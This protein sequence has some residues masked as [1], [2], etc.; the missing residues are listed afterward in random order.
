MKKRAEGR[1]NCGV[2]VLAS[3]FC[4]LYPFFVVFFVFGLASVCVCVCVLV[5]VFVIVFV[6]VFVFVRVCVCVCVLVC[7]FVLV[8]ASSSFCSFR[9]RT[10]N[11]Y[12]VVNE[13]FRRGYKNR[14]HNCFGV[15]A[16]RLRG[17]SANKGSI[18]GPTIM[19]LTKN[20]WDSS[21]NAFFVLASLFHIG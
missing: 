1:Q 17:K 9:N 4:L 10:L 11:D 13:A 18:V 5:F 7:V 14:H 6:F 19:R 16:K 21:E 3:F 20:V 12:A 2:C 8:L 15:G